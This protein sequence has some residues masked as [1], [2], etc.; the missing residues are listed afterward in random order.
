LGPKLH[1]QLKH[2]KNKNGGHD[3]EPKLVHPSIISLELMAGH[4]LLH[5][6]STPILLFYCCNAEH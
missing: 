5:R 6:R 3:E 1:L 4:L 2:E